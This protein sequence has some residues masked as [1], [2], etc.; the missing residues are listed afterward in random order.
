MSF[1]YWFV[2]AGLLLMI[3]ALS[4]TVLKRLPLSTALLYLAAGVVAGPAVLGLLVFD[5]LGEDGAP[6]LERLA[7]V[8]VIISLFSAG[9]KIRRPVFDRC[10]L[11]PARLAFVSMSVTVGLITL[12]GVFLL[13]LP[14]GAAVL[15]GAVLAPTDPVLA[16]DV[17]VQHAADDDRLRFAL[18][19]EAGLNDGTAFPFVYLGLG[20]LGLH[21]LGEFGWRWFAID[22]V[23]AIAGGLVIGG[24]MGWGTSKLVLY[25]RRRHKEAVGADDFLALG[26]IALSYGVALV[27][28]TWAFLA[29]FAAGVALRAVERTESAEA[30]RPDAEVQA[31]AGEEAKEEA[32]SNPEDAPAYMASAVLGFSEQLERIAAVAMVVVV[33]ALLLAYTDW[34]YAAIWFVPLVLL[35]IR[36]ISVWLGLLGDPSKGVQKELIGWFGIRGIG[37]VYYL[38]Y[39]VN[40]GLPEGAGAAILSLTLATIATS[41]V[42]HGVSVT[43]LM[44]WYRRRHESAGDEQPQ[45]T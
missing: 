5:P 19:G 45:T 16:S 23:Y 14:L 29:A 15:L 33:G 11:L 10:W 41:A 12:V 21:E 30:G 18:T 22:V 26:L 44:N 17:S 34:D 20:L 36:P 2:F 24:V 35:V 43:P 9:L 1:S 6:I 4:Q 38:A 37:S 27:A 40:A 32:A 42:V 3:M 7:E 31:A 39:A 28:G 13:D 8:A 25:L